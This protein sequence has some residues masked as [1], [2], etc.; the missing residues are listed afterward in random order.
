MSE[1]RI[2]FTALMFFTRIPCP[3]W[4]DH[5]E[6]YLNKSSRYFPLI[7]WIVGG[8]GGLALVLAVWLAKLPIL[9]AVLLSTV[10]TILLTGAFHEDGFADMC[11]GFGGGW[12][13]ERI[14]EIMQDSRLGTFGAV[15]LALLLG[16]KIA[17]LVELAT[18][19]S[20]WVAAVVLLA[21]HTVS[22]FVAVTFLMT[23]DYARSEEAIGASKSKPLATRMSTGEFAI[24]ALTGFTP[25]LCVVW[26][27]GWNVSVA[28][29]LSVA[30]VP[31]ALVKW[32]LGRFFTRWIG[33]YTGDCLGATQQVSEVVYYMT[34]T[35]FIHWRLM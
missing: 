12:T 28:A 9:V 22:R 21:G 18:V 20:A 30:L 14:L 24:A 35:C 16:L 23:H 34:I 8:V 17:C 13:K 7:G 11:D 6:E 31:L 25:M 26:V 32:W 1:L 19:R 33:G 15:G 4:V 3:A 29:W 5:S 2:F 27:L 10:V